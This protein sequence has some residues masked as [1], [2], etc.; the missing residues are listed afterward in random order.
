M[1]ARFLKNLW[2]N[3]IGINKILLYKSFVKFSWKPYQPMFN[4]ITVQEGRE[5]LFEEFLRKS[6]QLSL[7]HKTPISFGPYK[8]SGESGKSGATYIYVTH[9]DSTFAYLK[10]MSGVLFSGLAFK[11]AKCTTF[12]NWTYCHPVTRLKP[13]IQLEQITLVG[14]KGKKEKFINYLNHNQVMIEGTIE[15]I[16]TVRDT[17]LP[18]YIVLYNT[19]KVDELIATFREVGGSLDVYKVDLMKDAQKVIAYESHSVEKDCDCCPTKD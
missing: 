8:M 1:K 13:K 2:L 4:I 19:A 6:L 17:S 12:N 10:V 5:P 16:K 11:R 7:K 14:I 9:Y 18:N 3:T 15:K